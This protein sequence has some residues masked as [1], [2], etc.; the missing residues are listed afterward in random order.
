M[1]MLNAPS[2]FRLSALGCRLRKLE[3]QR[4]DSRI[5]REATAEQKFRRC[6]ALNNPLPLPLLLPVQWPATA[7]IFVV[8]AAAQTAAASKAA[9]A[10]AAAGI[11]GRL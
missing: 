1:E 7:S 9:A 8:A 6:A 2:L 4:I 5:V 3:E 10:A 11:V